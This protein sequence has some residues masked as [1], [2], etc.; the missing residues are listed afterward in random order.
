MNRHLPSL[1][2]EFHDLRNFFTT[3][4]EIN[5]EKWNH[6]SGVSVYEDK[7]QLFIELAMPGLNADEIQISFEKGVLWAK[8]ESKKELKEEKKDVKYHSNSSKAFSYRI[9][10]PSKVEESIAPKAKLKNGV[11]TVSFDKPK[12]S[13]PQQITIQEES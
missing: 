13:K 5:E 2:Q 12:A 4:D 11:L 3:L 9:P 7:D 10:L 6:F 1:F 8:G